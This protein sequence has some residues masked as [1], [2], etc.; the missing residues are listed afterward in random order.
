MRPR[1]KMHVPHKLNEQSPEGPPTRQSCRR[2]P[3][4]P[5]VEKREKNEGKSGLMRPPAILLTWKKREKNKGKPGL[6]RPPAL[7]LTWKKKEK[8]RANRA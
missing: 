7:L 3:T 6:V 8:T 5:D 2:R 4:P 1:N